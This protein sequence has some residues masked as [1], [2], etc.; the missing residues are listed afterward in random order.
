VQIEAASRIQADV[1][2]LIKTLFDRDL[3]EYQLDEMIE[4]AHHRGL[5]VL[6]E[7]HTKQEFMEAMNSEA[8]LIG[9]NN[10]N[11]RTL[12]VDLEVTETILE[13]CNFDKIIV[14]ESGIK[15]PRDLLRIKETGARAFLIG[16]AIMRAN[17]IKEAIQRFVLA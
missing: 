13:E 16:S 3:C 7:T 11:L 8:D 9:I 12:E 10:R 6:L 4:Y 15:T 14:S 2:L 5:E 17:D 1:V